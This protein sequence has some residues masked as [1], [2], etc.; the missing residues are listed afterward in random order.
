MINWKREAGRK[1]A[2][3]SP[4]LRA[5]RF[6]FPVKLLDE[7]LLPFVASS[8]CEIYIAQW[9][10]RNESSLYLVQVTG[11]KACK[12]V[13]A[14]TTYSTNTGKAITSIIIENFP[15]TV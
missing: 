5:L 13:H 7:K 4:A 8:L 12:N 14:D 6:E 3:V 10:D 15:L 9:K 11:I 1:A 2:A